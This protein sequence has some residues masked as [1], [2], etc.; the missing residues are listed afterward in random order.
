MADTI[1]R[2]RVS[3]AEH[4]RC[5]RCPKAGSAT[6][7]PVS[8]IR[9]PKVRSARSPRR[10]KPSKSADGGSCNRPA[11]R[12]CADRSRSTPVRRCVAAEPPRWNNPRNAVTMNV[13]WAVC[14]N[15]VRGFAWFPGMEPC[16]RIIVPHFEKYQWFVRQRSK[17]SMDDW[18]YAVYASHNA[19][20][21]GVESGPLPPLI[22][23]LAGKGPN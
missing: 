7:V 16:S 23:E 13:S 1:A 9:R 14:W 8:S 3:S 19:E 2:P 6:A 10:H 17:G 20:S 15:P 11:A 4:C 5:R 21:F 12:G 22:L 18:G